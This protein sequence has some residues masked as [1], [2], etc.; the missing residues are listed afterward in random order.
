M[1]EQYGFHTES[2]IDASD[3]SQNP[4]RNGSRKQ[5]GRLCLAHFD[6]LDIV[7]VETILEHEVMRH[8]DRVCGF[9]N[10]GGIT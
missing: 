4:R 2:G 9:I 6:E 3:H 8:F 1:V 7:F 10:I 5:M